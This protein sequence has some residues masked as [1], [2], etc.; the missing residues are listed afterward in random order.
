MV[1]AAT[2]GA[3]ETVV[4]EG[5]I[6]DEYRRSK[7]EVLAGRRVRGRDRS[8]DERAGSD[9]ARESPEH[10][11]HHDR[12]P[13]GACDRRVR[14]AG[15]PD[16][17]PRS[18]G[19]RG[20]AAD[21]RLC[22]ELDL[23]AEPRRDSDRPVLAPQR[24]DHVQS[25][26]QLAHDRGA[27]AAAGRLSHRDGRQV[28]PWQRSRRL[29]PMGDPARPGGVSQS[30]VLHGERREDL[31]RPI[32]DRRHHRPGARVPREPSARQAVLPDDASQGASPSLGAERSSRRAVRDAADSGTGHVLG[33]V[34]DTHGRA[35]R[36][37]AAR[38]GRSDQPRLETDAAGRASPGRTSRSGSGS[39]RTR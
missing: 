17:A 23:H 30:R 39:S 1:A 3:V 37:P 5:A 28:A 11:L 25:V 12:R 35:S 15:Q 26:R 31:H 4:V 36:E 7:S 19:A 33:L 34:R 24:R 18:P 27:A 14:V 20:R 21:E 6:D 38:R 13:R 29:R 10:H 8:A 22:H 16:A 32:R 9:P 2:V